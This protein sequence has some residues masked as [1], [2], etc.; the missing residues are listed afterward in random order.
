MSIQVNNGEV[1]DA[2]GEGQED[3]GKM[4]CIYELS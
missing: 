3:F 1:Y 4:F 2:V